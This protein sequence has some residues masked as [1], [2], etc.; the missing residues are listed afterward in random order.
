MKIRFATEEDA[1]S[2]LEIYNQYI[3]TS[4]TF[5]YVLPSEEEFRGRI[6]E[7]SKVY[8]YFV[9]EEDEKI[10]GYIYAHRG[11][12]RAAFQWN[13]EISIYLD[14]NICGRGLGK[15]LYAMIIEVLQLQGVKTVYGS[16]STPNPRS[17]KLHEDMGFHFLGAYHN[18]GFKA[19]A[20]RDL[21]WFEK[22]I[23]EY[24]EEPVPIKSIYE[25]DAELI[26]NII[27]KYE[28]MEQS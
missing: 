27:D 6:R 22:Q 9:C 8:P 7:Y 12:E 10:I 11:M 26:Q 18:T 14:K 15:K 23:G 28:I 20:W 5:E 13:A 2:L 25:I 19:G 4:I 24:D 17:V 3:D 16:V 21:M 1:L